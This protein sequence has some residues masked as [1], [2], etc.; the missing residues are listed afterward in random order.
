MSDRLNEEKEIIKLEKKLGKLFAEEIRSLSA[1]QLKQRLVGLAQH[2]Q[3]IREAK[4]NDEHL[5]KVSEEKK[6]LE[7]PYRDSLKDNELRSTFVVKVLEE[8]GK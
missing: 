6:Q 5:F 3:E 2:R 1:E 8:K 7:A 4:R